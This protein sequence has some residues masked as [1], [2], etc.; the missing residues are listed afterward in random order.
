[1]TERRLN[2][3]PG[4]QTLDLRKLATL[5]RLKL[6]QKILRREL[7]R[8]IA[9]AIIKKLTARQQLRYQSTFLRANE[10]IIEAYRR[11][12]VQRFNE[13]ERMVLGRMKES[14]RVIGKQ[15][16]R[17][18]GF[19]VT[20][21]LTDRAAWQAELTQDG[22][23]F[24]GQALDLGGNSQLEHLGAGVSFDQTDPRAI[25]WVQQNAKNA[26]FAITNTQYEAL[27][28]TLMEGIADGDTIAQLRKRLM[29]KMDIAR[30]RAEMIART[31][32]L[33]ASNRGSLLGM[34]QSG[35][36]EGKS[37]LAA[38]DRRTCPMCSEVD[39]MTM[40]L[41]EPFFEKSDK[42]IT[43]NNPGE[44]YEGPEL[45][46]GGVEFTFDYETIQH[47]PLHPSCLLPGT[48][49]ETPGGIIAG[50]RAWYRGKAIKLTFSDGSELS[51]T[52]NHMLLTPNGFASAQLLCKGG[53]V[54]YCPDF[55]GVVASNPNDNPGPALIEDIIESL[56][57][58]RSM[59]VRSVPV[60]AEYLHN[61]ARFVDGNI[62]V[63][64]ADSFLWGSI[65]AASPEQIEAKNFTASD[66]DLSKLSSAG[67]LTSMLKRLAFVA[68]GGMSGLRKPS[69]FYLRRLGHAKEH[70]L[71]TGAGGYAEGAEPPDNRT[72]GNIKELRELLDRFSDLIK[73][74]KITKVNVFSYHGPV[75]DLHTLT[76]LYISNGIISSNCRCTLL[77]ILK[78]T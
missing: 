44:E 32:T 18:D 57:V 46:E 67:N 35:V 69:S 26:A 41:D 50:L 70:S 48:R 66:S 56:T 4:P 1:M 43:F 53:D 49:C 72:P 42:P 17:K 21:W 38:A 24:T 58:N 65:Q 11:R 62:D 45:P 60:S 28:L 54:L 16:R 47:P 30:K 36:V 3:T 75:Y 68:D 27:R 71:T 78:E 51:V 12:L 13:L 6:K 14:R 55:K 5:V 25:S 33:K 20:Q 52:P 10:P 61:D 34:Q 15:A 74:K 22:Y 77:A 37:W 19:N 76:S 59:F 39:G 9:L 64:G 40:P 31:E 7:P 23:H 73:F 63:I 2:G 29:A 8:L